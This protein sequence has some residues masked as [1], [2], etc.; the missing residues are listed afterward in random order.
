MTSTVAQTK[1]S[2]PQLHLHLNL[3]KRFSHTI[4]RYISVVDT[5]GRVWVGSAAFVISC[6]IDRSPLFFGCS[7]SFI[8][9]SRHDFGSS[10][11]YNWACRAAGGGG[12]HLALLLHF[13]SSRNSYLFSWRG[14]T[15]KAKKDSAHAASLSSQFDLTNN[16]NRLSSAAIPG[17]SPSSLAWPALSATLSL[18]PEFGVE[19]EEGPPGDSNPRPLGLE[20]SALPLS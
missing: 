14:Q 18:C 20:S 7:S 6:C 17:N 15:K 8:M 5:D 9:R 3:N 19:S 16:C 12:W 2:R 11:Q 1:L 4:P 10:E 13:S